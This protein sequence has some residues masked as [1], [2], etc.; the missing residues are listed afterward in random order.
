MTNKGFSTGT[1]SIMSGG[2]VE[3]LTQLTPM[4]R[5]PVGDLTVTDFRPDYECPDRHPPTAGTGFP[6]VWFAIIVGGFVV[7]AL[8][9]LVRNVVE[10][11]L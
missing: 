3:V 9:L 1:A 10:K 7:V 8:V 11:I 2:S 6:G 5:K 4:L